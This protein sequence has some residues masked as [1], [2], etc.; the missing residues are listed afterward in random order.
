MGKVIQATII[1]EVPYSNEL[2]N[3]GDKLDK[4]LRKVID[5]TDFLNCKVVAGDN[6][7][8][9]LPVIRQ[10]DEY[11]DRARPDGFIFNDVKQGRM[12]GMYIPEHTE[13]ET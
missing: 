5:N 11:P 1:V 3:Y 10:K 2:M 13:D 8:N 4:E 9:K 6:L 7:H 12:K